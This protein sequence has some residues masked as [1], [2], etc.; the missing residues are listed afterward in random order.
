[1]TFGGI[2]ETVV[3]LDEAQA[4]Q[5]EELLNAVQDE[6]GAPG[7]VQPSGQTSTPAAAQPA[8][9]PDVKAKESYDKGQEVGKSGTG[10][11]GKEVGTAA[12][13][14]KDGGASGT[15]EVAA[16]SSNK[17]CNNTSVYVLGIPDDA[18]EDEVAEEFSRCGIISQHADGSPRV[19]LYRCRYTHIYIYHSIRAFPLC[20]KSVSVVACAWWTSVQ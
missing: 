10:E 16:G 17:K 2:D 5:E 20:A 3:T 11:G 19:K 4:E 1:M 7:A 12:A 15:Q 9:E 8:S 14:S 18:T 6:D 13:D